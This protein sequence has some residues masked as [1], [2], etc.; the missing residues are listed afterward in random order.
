MTLAEIDRMTE[1]LLTVLNIRRTNNQI[2]DQEYATRAVSIHA[3]AI[4]EMED[5]LTCSIR[6]SETDS[7]TEVCPLPN[8]PVFVEFTGSPRVFGPT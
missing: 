7:P 2:T 1:A 4:G 3:W 6:N 5:S 8:S